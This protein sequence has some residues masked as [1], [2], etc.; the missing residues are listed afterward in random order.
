MS[1]A[2]KAIID[3]I[4]SLTAEDRKALYELG[5]VMPHIAKHAGVER[6]W[7][8]R[9]PHCAHIALE[10]VGTKFDNGTDEAVDKPPLNR[11]MAVIPWV[12]PRAPEKLVNRES[13]VCQDCYNPVP[14]AL[15]CPIEK[16]VVNIKEFLA[17][18][19]PRAAAKAILDGQPKTMATTNPNGDPIVVSQNYD[20]PERR[21]SDGPESA[22]YS[23]AEKQA[24]NKLADDRDLMRDIYSPKSPRRG[25]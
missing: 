11:R 10:F 23:E 12:Q 21:A 24:I 2:T 3:T 7:G 1:E 8:Y 5:I 18:P 25:K 13:P 22:P 4:G 19:S 6:V 20:R 9:C 14:T 17:R 15:G 16:F